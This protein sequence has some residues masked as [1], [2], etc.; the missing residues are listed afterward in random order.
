MLYFPFSE[1]SPTCSILDNRH[2]HECYF[3]TL[4]P[5]FSE[6]WQHVQEIANHDNHL[7]THLSIPLE[8]CTFLTEFCTSGFCWVA[9][10][11][12]PGLA[13]VCRSSA[14][15][16]S[17]SIRPGCSTSAIAGPGWPTPG[18]NTRLSEKHPGKYKTQGIR[19]TKLGEPGASKLLI[20]RDREFSGQGRSTAP[21]ATPCTGWS[22]ARKVQDSV[23]AECRLGDPTAADS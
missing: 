18:K 13:V 2:N 5:I 20:C 4:N 9:K 19:S 11:R 17:A 23:N 16:A 22:A 8:S 3:L 12:G 1:T 21:A 14:G 6:V 15:A 10:C 7:A